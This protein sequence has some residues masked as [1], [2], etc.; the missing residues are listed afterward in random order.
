LFD[1]RDHGWVRQFTVVPG[2]VKL[3]FRILVFSFFS[4][5]LNKESSENGGLVVLSKP[6]VVF[7]AECNG[8]GMSGVVVSLHKS[9]S[10]YVDFVREL[11][12]EGG[13]GLKMADSLIISLEGSVI[14]PFDLKNLAETLHKEDV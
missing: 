6:N 14:K 11:R 9:Y 7:A 12:S 5:R 4:S 1:V 8:M 3:G 13:D 10:D 2:F